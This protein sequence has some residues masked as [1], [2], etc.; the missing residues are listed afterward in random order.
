MT[1]VTHLHPDYGYKG[2]EVSEND[3][4]EEC[5]YMYAKMAREEYNAGRELPVVDVPYDRLGDEA[6]VSVEAGDELLRMARTKRFSL[7]AK[8]RAEYD[9]LFGPP[10]KYVKKNVEKD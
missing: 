6:V 7:S 4:I 5:R 1:H 2:P 9:R 8:G 3:A 10:R